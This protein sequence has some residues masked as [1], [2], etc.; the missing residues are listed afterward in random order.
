MK[1]KLLMFTGVLFLLFSVFSSQVKK[2]NK[3]NHTYTTCT[4]TNENFEICTFASA[5][6]EENYQE[7][8]TYRKDNPDRIQIALEKAF[9]NLGL[10][11]DE[12]LKNF[13]LTP[14]DY[15]NLTKEQ[16]YTIDTS[17]MRAALHD[18]KDMEKVRFGGIPMRFALAYRALKSQSGTLE[19]ARK[20]SNYYGLK[21]N[22]L[23]VAELVEY[24]PS[25]YGYQVE[26][27]G[28]PIM[29]FRNS[30]DEARA[31][32]ELARIKYGDQFEGDVFEELFCLQKLCMDIDLFDM[33]KFL[34]LADQFLMDINS[35]K[36]EKRASISTENLLKEPVYK[37]N[38]AYGFITKA[39]G[40]K[41]RLPIAHVK[42]Q[43]L[44]I[45]LAKKLNFKLAQ[46]ENG[47]FYD[48]PGGVVLIRQI[49]KKFPKE[50]ELLKVYYAQIIL[51]AAKQIQ[52]LTGGKDGVPIWTTIHRSTHETG[53][54]T[55]A[56]FAV[57]RNGYGMK[58]RP[59]F[60][61]KYPDFCKESKKYKDE[62]MQGKQSFHSFTSLWGSGLAFKEFMNTYK[63]QNDPKI[64]DITKRWSYALYGID[65]QDRF[66][67]DTNSR[68]QDRCGNTWV[69]R[70]S[71]HN[72]DPDDYY[73]KGTKAWEAQY[74][75]YKKTML[76]NA[77]KH[78]KGALSWKKF[79]KDHNML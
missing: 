77:Q 59:F 51:P 25:Y 26:Y 24:R 44:I 62:K 65:Y 69:R 73:E 66:I 70:Y 68:F 32:A 75:V 4:K 45:D 21:V 61:P 19:R 56:L 42:H 38:D 22:S 27:N 17:F 79:L 46:A 1:S 41:V 52:E 31:F 16:Q 20:Y 71:T 72:A 11:I 60:C 10:T 53:L 54:G 39:N 7:V 3:T 15:D 74:K 35:K 37:P 28:D 43:E 12:N 14:S 76:Q 64:T 34:K 29:F 40:E 23:E 13:H 57:E 8:L 78:H 67:A 47:L 50:Y 55:S 2:A 48:P 18:A 33:N 36:T 49:S 58:E 9:L 6:S 5:K 63:C 30:W